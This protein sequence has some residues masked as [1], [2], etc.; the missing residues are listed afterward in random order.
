[1]SNQKS[2]KAERFATL[3]DIY[4]QTVNKMLDIIREMD[5]AEKER[6]CGAMKKIVAATQKQIG[7]IA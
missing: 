1:M 7:V 2:G 6:Y 5:E 3:F 4:S